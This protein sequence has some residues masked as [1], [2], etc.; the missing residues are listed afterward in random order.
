MTVAAITT[1]L[2]S[3]EPIS[4]RLR[5]S[6][7]SELPF[8]NTPLD[9]VV[10]FTERLR[11]VGIGGVCDPSS[12]EVFNRKTG[13]I[14]PHQLSAEFANEDRGRVMWLAED[15][16]DRDFE[17]R[18]HVVAKRTTMLNQQTT[19]P[20]GAGDL[21]RF[22]AKSPRP[23]T[24]YSAVG[25]VDFDGDGRLDLAGCWNY[26]RGPGEPWDGLVV[27]PRVGP[28]PTFEFGDLTRLRYAD[29]KT[30]QELRHVRHT[31]MAADF[32]DFNGDGKPDVI[33]TRK[34]SGKGEFLINTGRRDAGG[35]PILVPP[36]DVPV[37]DWE[38]CRAVDL[39]GDGALDLVVNGEFIRNENPR[40]W[41]F[42]SAKGVTLDAGRQ[43]CFVD[44]DGDGRL[45]AVCLRGKNEPLPDDVRVGWRRNL[46]GSPP[47]F[48]EE[49]ELT[50]VSR[51]ISC[52]MAG[53]RFR[54]GVT[55]VA[56][57][58]EGETT[59][60]L[61]QY[62]QYQR[63]GVFAL[64]GASADSPR[65]ESR[66]VASSRSA[67]MSLSD[68]AWP[69]LCDWDND[70]DVDLLIGGGYGAPRIVVN[71]GTAQAPRFAKP[72]WIESEGQPIRLLRNELLGEPHHWHNMGYSYPVFV[73]WDADELPDLVI[74][75]ETNRI[76]WY[77]NIGKREKPAFGPR[78]M[79]RVEGFGDAIA[80]SGG[81]SA[82]ARR[83][84]AERAIR[85]TYPLEAEQPFFWRTGAA[86]ADFDG[87]GLTD[88]VT[89]DGETRRGTLFVQKRDD[90]GQLVLRKQG[91]LALRDGRPI[92]DRL[93]GRRAHWTESFRACDWDSDGLID[94]VY[95]VAGADDETQDR[96]SIYL[97]RNCGSRTEPLFE[98]PVTLR[99]F[100][101]PIRL[102]SHGPHPGV[103][104]FDGDGQPDLLPC[105]EWSVYPFYRHAALRMLARPELSWSPV[106][107][108]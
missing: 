41:P 95:S 1:P 40:G 68:Q 55:F 108:R 67:V 58:H 100:G 48:G 22:N 71:E 43:P 82:T 32:A 57:A 75:N 11:D 46:G 69:S 61:V 70:G 27:Y 92:D 91:A 36:S 74:P 35:W 28:D 19:A 37:S 107:A 15:P 23:V 8:R 38:G 89:H 13:K 97:L 73:R 62:D 10:D 31:Y 96:G 80:D 59:L 90:A 94:L 99:C 45:D 77:Q 87:D 53:N 85:D 39:D 29:A 56:A 83:R 33:V 17:I 21:L 63:L 66:G 52:D 47:A 6:V 84:S 49:R 98:A 64:I 60:L 102:T 25:L 72:R 18:F 101:E 24:L 54:E 76:Y 5:A 51:E 3:A 4:C 42:Q 103:G 105:V 34:G 44:L 78:R 20:I 81:D 106:E 86:L 9:P 12:I 2:R 79:L 93:I 14:V 16:N 50:D 65:F 88:L 7:Q 104:D 30:P 26:A